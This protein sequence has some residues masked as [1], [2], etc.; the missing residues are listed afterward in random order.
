MEGKI[1]IVAGGI[2][3]AT[4][5]LFVKH[6]AKVVIADINDEIG[7]AFASS[8]TPFATYVHCNVSL[9]HEVQNLIDSTISRH[10]RIDILFNNAGVLGN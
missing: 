9:E 5:R 6:G 8:L 3:V 7:L 1:A 10:G 2:G 4:M